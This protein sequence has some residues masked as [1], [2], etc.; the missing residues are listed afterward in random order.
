MSIRR[1]CDSCGD[2]ITSRNSCHKGGDQSRLT[3]LVKKADRTGQL[4]VEVIVSKGNVAND[5]D[6]CKYCVL[7]ALAKL[8]DR[9]RAA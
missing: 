3:A 1:F 4:G 8:D 5:G 6:W 9:P 7:D 2:E